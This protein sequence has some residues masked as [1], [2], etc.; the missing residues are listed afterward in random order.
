MRRTRRRCKN[1]RRRAITRKQRGRGKEQR[2][3]EDAIRYGTEQVYGDPDYDSANEADYEED[4]EEE[5]ETES[6]SSDQES[7]YSD[8]DYSNYDMD[9]YGYNDMDDYGYNDSGVSSEEEDILIQAGYD[10]NNFPGVK[11]YVEDVIG[12]PLNE[13]ETYDRGHQIEI[14]HGYKLQNDG[15]YGGKR[16]RKGRGKKR[17]TKRRGRKGKRRVTRTR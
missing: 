1:Q 9:D 7:N 3:I 5:L 13:F 16:R 17:V 15:V 2:E 8:A 14:L 11:F 6:P 12:I 10:G 4:Y